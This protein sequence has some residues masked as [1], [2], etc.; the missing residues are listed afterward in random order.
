MSFRV[1]RSDDSMLGRWWWTVDRKLLALLL[2]LMGIGVILLFAASP[3]VA[4]GHRLSPYYFIVRQML[5]L[6]VAMLVLVGVSMLPPKQVRRLAAVGLVVTLAALVVTLF[7]A[8]EVKGARRWISVAGFSLQ[9]SEFA[10]PMLA[11]TTAWMLAEWARNPVFPGRL[12]AFTLYIVTAGLIIAQPDFGMTVVLSA[13]WWGQFFLAGMPL[14]WLVIFVPAV[15]VMGV[16]AYHLLSHVKSRVD[17]F[18]SPDAGDT[19]QID[20]SVRA[21]NEG[22]WL[23]VGPGEGRIKN[24]LPDAHADFIFAVAAEEFGVIAC[25]LLI[26]LVVAIFWRGMRLALVQKN[27]FMLLAVGGILIQFGVQAFINIASTVHLIPTK[28]MTLP[29]ISYG[30]SS[31]LAVAFGMGVVLA[32][33]R[34]GAGGTP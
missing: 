14:V 3:A 18:L 1:A 13:V 23:G 34:R 19:Y 6:P 25:S 8:V 28:G 17:R 26:I 9:A 21:I 33:T 7:I 12:A 2:V 32:L 29:F 15:G 31:L 4:E 16:A 11:V 27:M 20:Q 22:G 30:G 24:V 10:K 5:M